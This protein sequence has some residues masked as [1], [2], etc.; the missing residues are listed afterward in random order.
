[1]DQ[2]GGDPI[3]RLYDKAILV[4]GAAVRTK[5]LLLDDA[6]KPT[7]KYYYQTHVIVRDDEQISLR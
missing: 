1:L 5:I 4:K 2:V 3:Q 6:G 7:G